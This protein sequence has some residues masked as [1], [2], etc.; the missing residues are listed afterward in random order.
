MLLETLGFAGLATMVL[1]GV[2]ALAK[3]SYQGGTRALLSKHPARSA[4]TQKAHARP[5]RR[6]VP[7][8][9]VA[10]GPSSGVPTG[11]AATYTDPGDGQPD[12]I[13]RD[14]SGK[15][16]SFSA[17]CTHAGCTVG[18]ES[19]QIVCPCHGGVYDPST[20]AVVSSANS[21]VELFSP[22]NRRT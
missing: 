9:A 1:G 16:R 5:S 15:L 3:G 18:Y 10:I 6:Q 4:G 22:S 12:I 2:S 11:Q 17:V 19:G 8:G 7:S 13:I 20:G 21:L 14:S